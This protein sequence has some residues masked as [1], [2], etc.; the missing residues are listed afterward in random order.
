M[1]N[2]H[3]QIVKMLPIYCYIQQSAHQ[4]VR[5]VSVLLPTTALATVD[6]QEV[7]ALNVSVLFMP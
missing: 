1:V 5:M 2:N 4:L 7:F 3:V 6:G